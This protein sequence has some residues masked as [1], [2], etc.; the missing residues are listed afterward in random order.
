MKNSASDKLR[1]KVARVLEVPDV[2]DS[3]WNHL[4]KKTDY[5]GEALDPAP[6]TAFDE[7]V[8]QAESLMEIRRDGRK[9]SSSR[10]VYEEH[11]LDANE[12]EEYHLDVNE[13]N[14]SET[15]R[16][17]ALSASIARRVATQPSVRRFRNR[18]LGSTLL[19]HEQAVEF[20]KSPA[21]CWLSLNKFEEL[22]IPIIDHRSF[23]VKER[24]DKQGRSHF[25]EGILHIEWAGGSYEGPFR[26]EVNAAKA[27][28]ARKRLWFLDQN[29]HLR[30]VV[31]WRESVFGELAGFSETFAQ[32]YEW[33][34]SQATLFMLTGITPWI[35]PIISQI[36]PKL[37]IGNGDEN[38]MDMERGL[39]RLLVDATVSPESVAR[40]YRKAQHELLGKRT[41]SLS[42][43]HCALVKFIAEKDNFDKKTWDEKMRMWNRETPE[44]EWRYPHVRHFGQA[45]DRAK[46]A[47]FFPM[48]GK[49]RVRG[50]QKPTA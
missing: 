13:I 26:H 17:E 30:K 9:A 29:N 14:E 48:G 37:V 5:V 3:I 27:P 6:P 2:P 38:S 1:Q 49:F 50:G 23:I 44:P 8:E 43:R 10:S 12:I 25:I 4:E 34:E 40:T 33:Q 35:P 7:L 45:V 41:H 32:Q 24:E 31:A 20:L 36:I 46:R 28:V 21:P 18:V 39:I 47:V 22:G 15:A 42:L 11:H 16:A 19:S